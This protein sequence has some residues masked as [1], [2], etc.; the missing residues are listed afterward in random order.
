MKI[1]KDFLSREMETI[2]TVPH[3]EFREKIEIKLLILYILFQSKNIADQEYIDRQFLNDFCM[4]YIK[5]NYFDL[6]ECVGML[7]DDAAI[8]SNTKNHR[9]VL[10][11]SEKGE[12]LLSQFIKEL[13][14]S[15]RD[16][17]DT[18]IS[19]EVLKYR[20]EKSVT[21]DYWVEGE[22]HFSAY[23]AISDEEMPAMRLVMTFPERTQ[24]QGV[25]NYFKNHPDVFYKK[26]LDIC[27]E[28]IKENTREM[29][30]KYE[31]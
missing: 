16:K 24:A 25:Q 2:M 10:K 28:A 31:N 14:F 21:S 22:H 13:P 30:E 8:L 1:I 6:T 4:E 15:V 3:F 19:K 23:L 18:I 11:L 29:K 9:E 12:F 5:I 20:N 27:D 7:I 17:V 26:L